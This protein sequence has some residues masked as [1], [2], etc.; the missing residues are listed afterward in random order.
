MK[1]N[2]DVPDFEAF[3]IEPNNL[4]RIFE[5]QYSSTHQLT[6]FLIS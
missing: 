1:I 5:S 6:S 4:C 3:G 2:D